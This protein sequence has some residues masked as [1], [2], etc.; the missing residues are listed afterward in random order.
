MEIFCLFDVYLKMKSSG[1]CMLWKV[2][3]REGKIVCV[4]ERKR[5]DHHSGNHSRVVDSIAFCHVPELEIQPDIKT[6]V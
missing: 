5:S 3:S 1:I 6:Y 4:P 2:S